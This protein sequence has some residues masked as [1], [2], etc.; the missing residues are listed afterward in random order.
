MVAHTLEIP[1]DGNTHTFLEGLGTGIRIRAWVRGLEVSWLIDGPKKKTRPAFFQKGYDAILYSARWEGRGGR[2][3]GM[4]WSERR[5]REGL[6]FR[7]D[8]RV[9]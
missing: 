5:H 3:G 7:D 8:L 4:K 2:G 6:K 9:F 1:S